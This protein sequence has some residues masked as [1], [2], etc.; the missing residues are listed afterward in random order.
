MSNP[1]APLAAPPATVDIDPFG[2]VWPE[3]DLA[4]RL[5]VVLTALAVGLLA[6]MI[7]PG[8]SH[9]LGTSLVALAVG[10]TAFVLAPRRPDVVA[11]YVLAVPLASMFVLRDAV[12]ID[13]L[14]LLAAGAVGCLA[15]VD[16]RTLPAVIASFLAPPLAGLRA[17]PWLA[18]TLRGA[19]RLGSLWPVLRTGVLSVA[20]V[21]VFGALFA[22]AEPV[23]AGWVDAVLP[24]LTVD[25][26]GQRIVLAG[27][28]GAL[29]LAASYVAINPPP[30][31]R[32]ATGAPTPVRRTWEWLVPV[33]LV[34]ALYVGFVTAQATVMFGGHAYLQRTT[35][36]TYAEHV[37]QGFGQLTVATLLTL[38]VVAIAARKAPRTTARDRLVLRIALGLL[39]LLTL[40]VVASALYR[41]HVYEQAYGFTAL[42]VLVSAFEG[43]LGLVVLLVVAAGLRLDGRWLPRTVVLSG[44]ATLLT[45]AAINPEGYV[46]ERNVERYLETGKADWSYLAGL[47]A[48]AVPA[49]RRLPAQV[50]PCVFS[51]GPAERDD[52]LAW[53]LARARA[54]TAELGFDGTCRPD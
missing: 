49:L 20:L 8:R 26:L 25:T 32:L 51:A 13:V 48:D 1:A 44:A 23:F 38:G 53:N 12:W 39:C 18:R 14:C 3:R 29:T 46:A 16:A 43:W 31:D 34:V 19:A 33:G 27:L 17:L 47:S 10:T 22:S 5:P 50:Q 7:L 40:V 11:S 35:G 30:V 42:R 9:G 28:V 45:L 36:L 21:A 2:Q 24:D 4:P 41:M 37:H 54:G 6:A 52:L 15:L